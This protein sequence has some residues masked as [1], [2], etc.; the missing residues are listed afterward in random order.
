MAALLL[1]HGAE[2]NAQ[3]TW[4]DT[5]LHIAAYFNA[6]PV[7]ELLI[8]RGANVQAKI[9]A[10]LPDFEGWTPLDM[11]IHNKAAEAEALLRR[12]EAPCN[13]ECS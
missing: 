7:A 9:N 11:S 6:L 13:K 1:A 3:N 2:V 10:N 4:G 8:G 12:H 5:P